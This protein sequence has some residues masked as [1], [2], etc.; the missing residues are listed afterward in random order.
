MTNW[1][2]ARIVKFFSIVTDA[3]TIIFPITFIV[4]N[5]ITE[6]YGYKF[7]RKAI[8]FGFLFN[9][10]FIGYGFLVT[11]MDSPKFALDN[12]IFDKIFNM[13]IWIISASFISYWCCEPTNSYIMAKIKLFMHGRLISLRFIFLTIIASFFDSIVFTFIAF[14][15]LFPYTTT[16]SLTIN[17]SLVKI[18]IEIA[19]LL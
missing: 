8:W 7:A 4:S 1:Y 12:E 3:G 10:A 9:L 19:G 16:W 14:S 13:N 15:R 6:V 18:T 17:M 11:H 5:L 2:N